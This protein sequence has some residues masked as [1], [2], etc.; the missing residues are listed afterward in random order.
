MS[1]GQIPLSQI[2]TQNAIRVEAV[3][4]W[5]FLNSSFS[6]ISADSCLFSNFMADFSKLGM[7]RI[8]IT[9]H[10]F[11]SQMIPKHILILKNPHYL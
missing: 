6:K 3:F 2:P 1:K 11:S 5:S 10:V 9:S 4:R 8:F 7:M